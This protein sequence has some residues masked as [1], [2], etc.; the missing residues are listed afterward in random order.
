MLLSRFVP[1]AY[2]YVWARLG[3]SCF[4]EKAEPGTVTGTFAASTEGAT[5]LASRWTSTWKWKEPSANVWLHFRP[6]QATAAPE[7]AGQIDHY[8]MCCGSAPVTATWAWVFLA[9]PPKFNKITRFTTR[10]CQSSPL[11]TRMEREST[12]Q[13]KSWIHSKVPRPFPTFHSLL[14]ISLKGSRA[15]RVQGH[16]HSLDHGCITHPHRL[17]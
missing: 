14:S 10:A 4:V 6:R 9:W 5:R 3:R 8:F 2:V 17:R 7:T 1:R 12:A 11:S 15:H 16:S 13:R